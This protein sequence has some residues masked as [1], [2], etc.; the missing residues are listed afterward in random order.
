MFLK[1]LLKYLILFIV[2][3]AIYFGIECAWK[4]YLT[5]W[6]M[7][8][9]AGAVGILIGGINECIPWEMPFWQQCSIGMIIA[10]LAE[11]ITG[12][13]VNQ[14]LGLGVWHY[15]LLVFFWGQCSLPFMVAWFF[16]AGICILIDDWLRWKWFN[17]EEPY[18]I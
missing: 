14:W 6:S 12:L 4:G 18:Y 3:G 16:L 8:V 9:L 2:F 15:N 1:R 5:H 10:T 13:I 7:F 17:E 11:G